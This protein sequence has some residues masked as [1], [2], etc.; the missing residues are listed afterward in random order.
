MDR[1]NMP[2]KKEFEGAP[3]AEQKRK[4]PLFALVFFCV[5][6]CALVLY[7]IF[8][9]SPAFSDFFNRYI[10]SAVRAALAYATRIFPFSFAEFCSLLKITI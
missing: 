1:E 4:L 10:S 9:L 3:K 6:I 5:G 2:M 7:L 8:L